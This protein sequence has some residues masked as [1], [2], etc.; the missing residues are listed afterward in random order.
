M[1]EATYNPLKVA[2]WVEW[3]NCDPVDPRELIA[4]AS[5]TMG[6]NTDTGGYL[7]SNNFATPIPP[8]LST[9]VV[10]AVDIASTSTGKVLAQMP[11]PIITLVVNVGDTP[12]A[13]D[14]TFN[15]APDAASVTT[16]TFIVAIS[17]SPVAGAISFLSSTQARF[18]ASAP[19]ASGTTYSVALKGVGTPKITFAGG[20]VALDGQPNELPSGTGT[21]GSSFSFQF[22]VVAAAV[23][24]YPGAVV[25]GWNPTL[26]TLQSAP[27][28][29]ALGTDNL[30]S[31]ANANQWNAMHRTANLA[32]NPAL[33]NT[34]FLRG[35][36]F[37]KMAI[38]LN[39][40]S[41]SYP[42]IQIGFRNNAGTRGDCQGTY[43]VISF[44]QRNYTGS[45]TLNVTLKQLGEFVMGLT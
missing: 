6:V 4:M 26:F 19:F 9:P 22:Q 2:D 16:N 25:G 35:G 1:G 31:V 10:I 15:Q 28:C 11:V 13:V 21:P 20:T 42:S 24:Y 38:P 40:G 8:T 27:L 43:P 45:V 41:L 17:G 23:T 14:I 5:L 12:N 34:I 39:L 36:L 37:W 29:S 32:T 30:Q 18:T 44:A 33:V 3:Q 7:N